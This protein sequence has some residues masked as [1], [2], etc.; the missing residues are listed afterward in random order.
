MSV[1]LHREF[2]QAAGPAERKLHSPNLVLTLS[3]AEAAVM[4]DLV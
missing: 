1:I 3:L 2:F 4:A